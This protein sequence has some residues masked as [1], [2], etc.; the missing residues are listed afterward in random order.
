MGAELLKTI[1]VKLEKKQDSIFTYP[2]EKQR[3]YVGHFPEP[4]DGFDRGYFQYCCQ[5]KQYGEPIHGFLNLSALP[6]SLY[7]MTS[8][9][10]THIEKARTV[11]AVFFNEGKPFN[12]IP[13][14]VTETSPDIL[15]VTGDQRCLSG[16]DM[17]FLKKVFRKHPFSWMLWLKVIL[18]LSQYSYAIS[19]YAPKAIISCNEF[20]YTAPIL[21]EYCRTRGVKSINVMHGEKLYT[22]RDTF[23]KY[24]EFYVWSKEY[25]DLLIDLRADPDQFRIEVPQSLRINTQDRLN[26]KY[27][28]TYYLASESEEELQKICTMLQKLKNRNLNV[29]VRPHPRYSDLASVDR[30]FDFV[31]IEDTS[32]LTIEQSLLQTENAIAL[33]STVLTQAYHA[34]IGIVIDDVSATAKYEKLAQLGYVML[35]VEHKLLSSVSNEQ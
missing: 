13:D 11:D 3:K 33:Y 34:G 10:K 7:Y 4:K 26:V 8:F 16:E 28:Y 35:K 6:L 15:T 29:A 21:T 24:D 12:I 25:A 2:V 22:M 32:T 30:I 9:R 23:I 19:K 31:D 17:T 5:M 27:D 20:S 14:C 1:A 18:K